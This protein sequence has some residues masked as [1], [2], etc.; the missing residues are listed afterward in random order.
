VIGLTWLNQVAEAVM[1]IGGACA[2]GATAFEVANPC[3]EGAWMA[4]V[5]LLAG[6]ACLAAYAVLRPRGGPQY[7]LLAWPALFGTLGLQFLRAAFDGNGIAY[8]FLLCGVVFVLMAV[9][10]L[11]VAFS[12]G[13]GSPRRVLVGSGEEP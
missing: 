7:L 9:A 3:P 10:P 5:G 8:G 6:T 13:T 1:E 2:S 4:P 11:A 12:P